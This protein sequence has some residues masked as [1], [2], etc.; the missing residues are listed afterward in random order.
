MVG[1]SRCRFVGK[2]ALCCCASGWFSGEGWGGASSL[3]SWVLGLRLD[4]RLQGLV[5]HPFF[6]SAMV[7]LM[8]GYLIQ[9][10]KKPVAAAASQDT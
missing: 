3:K 4:P 8:A 2:T 9:E 10:V 6:D 1:H 5:L 7:K